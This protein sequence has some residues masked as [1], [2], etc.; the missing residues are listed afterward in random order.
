MR[1]LFCDRVLELETG[2]RAVATKAISIGDE[3]L[4]DHY[5]R[6]P[7]MPAS[8][9]L[10]SLVQVA[11]WLYIVTERFAITTVLGLVEGVRICGEGRPGD[12]LILE[13]WIEYVHRGGAT[14]RGSVRVYDIE[15]L[16]A[17]RLVF[18]SKPVS[19]ETVIQE[20]RELFHYLSGGFDLNT[21]SGRVH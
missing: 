11:G 4:Q 10:E 13:V 18:A 1:F 6:R 21:P 19:D 8:L 15:I 7:I 2:R 17:D 20:S 16:C 9:L 5:T 3:F 12:T 14:L